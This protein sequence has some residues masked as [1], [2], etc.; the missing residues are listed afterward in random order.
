MIV[1]TFP[2]IAVQELLLTLLLFYEVA[3][4]CTCRLLHHRD[5]IL[6]Q[7]HDRGLW[8]LENGVNDVAQGAL[9]INRAALYKP[10]VS[11]YHFQKLFSQ[12]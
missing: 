10:I 12:H 5:R 7:V 1:S 11:L 2:P 4:D 6:R 3:C 9:R 8:E